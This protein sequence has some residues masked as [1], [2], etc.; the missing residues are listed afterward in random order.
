[1]ERA[2]VKFEGYDRHLLDTSLALLKGVDTTLLTCYVDI[3]IVLTHDQKHPI[4]LYFRVLYITHKRYFKNH[5]NNLC[6]K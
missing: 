6:N 2:A 5:P 4:S 3:M 1:M